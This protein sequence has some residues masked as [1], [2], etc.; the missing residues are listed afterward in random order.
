MHILEWFCVQC[1]HVCGRSSRSEC[2]SWSGHVFNVFM[3]V[4][5]LQGTSAYRGM[6]MYSV[7]SCVWQVFKERVRIVEW[8][9]DYDKLRSG[10]VSKNNFRRGLD[11]CRFELA[12]SEI[13]I[14]ED[15]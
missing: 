2:V 14:L 15:Q 13:A 10:R 1:I 11:L 12:E 6:V 9:R 8:L 3:C 7:Y 5:G 4:A